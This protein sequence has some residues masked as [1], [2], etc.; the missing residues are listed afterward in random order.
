MKDL[1]HKKSPCLLAKANVKKGGVP[2][3]LLLSWLQLKKQIKHPAGHT[4]TLPLAKYFGVWVLWCHHTYMC[5]YNHCALRFINNITKK[6]RPTY[7]SW[8]AKKIF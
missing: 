4:P 3:L 7:N 2:G 1:K 5:S 6:G 8:T